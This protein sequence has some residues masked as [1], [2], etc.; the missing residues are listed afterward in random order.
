M[1]FRLKHWYPFAGLH[2]VTFWKSVNLIIPR[3]EKPDM[4]ALVMC[5][6]HCWHHHVCTKSHSCTCAVYLDYAYLM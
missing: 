2:T 4:I 5:Y 3:H 1:Q 6:K